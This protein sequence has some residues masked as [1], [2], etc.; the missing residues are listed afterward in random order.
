[1]ADDHNMSPFLDCSICVDRIVGIFIA[2]LLN[3]FGAGLRE[4]IKQCVE[5]AEKDPERMIR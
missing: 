3:Y 2:L 5:E 1:M 4:D